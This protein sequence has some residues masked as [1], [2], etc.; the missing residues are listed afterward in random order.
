MKK[1]LQPD[2]PAMLAISSLVYEIMA[3]K[4]GNISKESSNPKLNPL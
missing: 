1:L 4:R 3:K 2:R